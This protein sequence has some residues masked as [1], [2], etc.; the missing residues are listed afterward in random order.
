MTGPRVLATMTLVVLLS[1]AIGAQK[2]TYDVVM[3][4]VGTTFGTLRKTLDSGDLGAAA[5]DAEKLER[6]FKEV[7]DFWTPFKTKD[8]I[9]TARGAR[10]AF[11]A[12]AVAAR[13]KDVPEAGARASGIGAFCTRCHGSH[14]EQMP[15]KTYRIKP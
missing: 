1:G 11:T 14:R 12:V 9:D 13:A 5:A 6:L 10:D 7:E 4:E 8:A 2:R 15:D 3:K